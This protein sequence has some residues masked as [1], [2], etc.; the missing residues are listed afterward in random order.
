MGSKLDRAVRQSESTGQEF[1]KIF[2]WPAGPT[3]I[4]LLPAAKMD[5]EDD[6]FLAVGLHY[7]IEKYPIM[8]PNAT[9]WAGDPCPLC[10]MVE[11]LRQ[12]GMND[13]ANKYLVR[14]PFYA[15][16]IIRGQE[17]QGVQIV[18]LPSTLFKAIITLIK[19]T[20]AYGDVLSPGP[21]GKDI[22]ITKE[23]QNLQTTYQA[24]VLPKE[25]P[26]LPT[27]E[28]TIAV[29]KDLPTITSIVE[30]PD[31]SELEAHVVSVLGIASP[32]GDPVAE[33]DAGGWDDDD[34]DSIKVGDWDDPRLEDAP[35]N[36]VED[37]DSWMGED[38]DVS[39]A[40]LVAKARKKD[41]GDDIVEAIP[42]AKKGTSRKK[43]KD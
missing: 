23:G 19:D 31:Q 42:K 13:A 24:N 38:D 1:L 26:L 11:D 18:R 43:K 39:S 12:S 3:D 4:R 37:D 34:G 7:G 10:K 35:D 9:D 2:K 20:E 14:K 40:E 5:D 29:L 17:D 32:V 6:W 41:I 27:K 21:H 16:A 25:R 33:D 15:R 22:R 30:I 28:T 36:P 8:C